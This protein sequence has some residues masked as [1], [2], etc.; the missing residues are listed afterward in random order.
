[1]SVLTFRGGVHPED[2]KS[3]SKNEQIKRLVPTG[4]IVIPLSQHIGAPAKPCIAVGERVLVGQKIGEAVGFI[5]ANVHSSVSGTVKKIEPRM[6]AN[7]SK[8][9]CVIIENDNEYEE[10]SCEQKDFANMTKEEKRNA[11]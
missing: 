11:I 8:V 4:E 3:L 1:M 9:D 2:G 5:S 10:N 7:G 6:V